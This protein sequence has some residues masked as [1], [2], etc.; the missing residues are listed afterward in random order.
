MQKKVKKTS[1]LATVQEIV[2][3]TDHGH[4]NPPNYDVHRIK[5][6]VLFGRHLQTCH[7]EKLRF[8]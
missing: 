5:T 6:T 4:K 2:L 7:Y 3:K 8:D 1:I